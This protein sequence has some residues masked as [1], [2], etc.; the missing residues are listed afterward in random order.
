MAEP[1]AVP[2]G[3]WKS[4]FTSDLVASHG[5]EADPPGWGFGQVVLDGEDVYWMEGRPQEEGRCVVMPYTGD[6]E[7]EVVT[8][9]PS[10]ADDSI[11]H[12]CRA[13]L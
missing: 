5:A 13:V 9:A 12:P 4:P 7:N 6:G 10:V 3:S 2:Y 1:K 11:H 8:P